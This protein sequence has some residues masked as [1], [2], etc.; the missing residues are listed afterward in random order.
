MSFSPAELVPALVMIAG[1]YLALGVVFAVPFV[2]KG[3]NRLDP[4]ARGGTLG[5]RVLILPGCVLLWPAMLSRWVKS[6]RS[7]GTNPER[8]P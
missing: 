5:F 1:L 4:A 6:L 8:T 7:A 3:V 2:L